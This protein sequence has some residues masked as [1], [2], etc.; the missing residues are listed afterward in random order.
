LMEQFLHHGI[1]AG[2]IKNMK[3]VFDSPQA[4]ASILEDEMSDGKTAKR[5]SQIAFNLS[6]Q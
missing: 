4:Q 3:E 5:V 2:I 6:P 1:P